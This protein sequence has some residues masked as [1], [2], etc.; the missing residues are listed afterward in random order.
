MDHEIALLITGALVVG[1]VLLA[2]FIVLCIGRQLAVKL[3]HAPV[4]GFLV[5]VPVVNIGLLFFFAFTTSPLERRIKFLEGEI[6][7]RRS[8]DSKSKPREF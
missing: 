3:G 4:M 1:A 6:Q 5:L 7:R 8:E 2:L